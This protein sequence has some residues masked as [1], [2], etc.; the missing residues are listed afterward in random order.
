MNRYMSRAAVAVLCVLAAISP[1]SAQKT[2]APAQPVTGSDHLNVSGDV[3]TPFAL[4][5]DE[6]RAL[7]HK[8]VSVMNTHENKQEIYEGVPVADL[9][10]RAGVPQGEGM[11]G[12]A[13]STGVIAG[14]ADGYRVLFSLGD[15]DLSIT[16][17]QAIVADRMNGAPIP[18]DLGPLR[19]IVPG[20]KR[21]ARWVRMLQSL[22]VIKVTA[23]A[24]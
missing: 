19:L 21:P 18:G 20:D 8:T 23:P 5:L 3:P 13:L 6:L 4:S 16:D 11:R 12:P 22:T 17:S 14:A 9:L 7:P 24:R 10:K 1:T 15:L 2:A